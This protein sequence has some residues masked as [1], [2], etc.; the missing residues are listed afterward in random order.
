M[1]LEGMRDIEMLALR[2]SP[3][4]LDLGD[5]RHD[6]AEMIEH[7]QIGII[8][9]P[10]AMEREIVTSRRQV[11]IVGIGLPDQAHA[12]NSRVKLRGAFHVGNFQCEVAKSA[13]LYH[14]RFPVQRFK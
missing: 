4:G 2:P 13:M 7:L 9:M 6:E 8:A 11:G 3:C 10:A 1:V 5:A 12:E 14:Y